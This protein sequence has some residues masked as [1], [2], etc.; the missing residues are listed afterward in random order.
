MRTLVI[1]GLVLGALTGCR[2]ESMSSLPNASSMQNCEDVQQG[3]A[4][5]TARATKFQRLVEEG[6]MS[7]E[8]AEA[9]RQVSVK[10]SYKV[11]ERAIE[12]G[13]Q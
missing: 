1:A 7:L 5:A 11:R 13:C 3:I 12:L 10:W 8:E 4:E 6:D 2:S 9:E